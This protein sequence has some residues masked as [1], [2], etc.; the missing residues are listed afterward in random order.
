MHPADPVGRDLLRADRLTFQ[1]AAA[2]A[3]AFSTH[4]FLHGPRTAAPFRLPLGKLSQVGQLGCDK[5][6]GGCI[7]AAGNAGTT[8]DAAGRFE[9]ASCPLQA[10]RLCVAIG[11]LAGAGGAVPTSGD[12]AVQG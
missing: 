1:I 2:A 5:Q 9:G 4:L 8:A 10:H 3:K 11:G 6:A 12:Q 7:A